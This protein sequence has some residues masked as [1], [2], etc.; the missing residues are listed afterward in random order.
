M[1]PPF[2][3][4]TAQQITMVE[5]GSGTGLVSLEIARQL[6][7][8]G[9]RATFVQTDL[10]EVCKLLSQTTQHYRSAS[11]SS[12]QTDVIVHP[13]AWGDTS[14]ASAIQSLLS[15]PPTHLICCDL[16][17]F[18]ELL[19][20]L[21]RSLL[22]L[23]Q[24]NDPTLIMAYKPRSA[25]KETSFWSA[26]GLWFAYAP[27]RVRRRASDVGDD[28]WALLGAAWDEPMF[29]FTGRR[30]PESRDWTVP[31]SDRD[32]LDGVGAQGTASRKG[33]DTFEVILLMS[34]SL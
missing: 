18:P 24:T 12:T 17:Y 5:L 13:L 28:S 6:E 31:E 16:V 19:A 1:D 29:V 14:H 20:P 4:L 15:E 21:L 30:R 33:D 7:V 11:S 10:P 2:V 8:S 34:Q 26:L 32:L 25:A 22:H 23:T 3:S 27:V 9:R